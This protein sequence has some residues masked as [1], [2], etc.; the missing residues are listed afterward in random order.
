MTNL[1]SQAF[2]SKDK[3]LITFITGG[4]PDFETSKKII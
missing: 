4:D 2:S 1:I 3:K